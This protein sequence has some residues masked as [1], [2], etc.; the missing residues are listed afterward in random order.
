MKIIGFGGKGR[1]GKTTTAVFLSSWIEETFDDYYVEI[2]PFALPLKI[3]V[4]QKAGYSSWMEYKEEHPTMYR[5]ECQRLGSLARDEYQEYWIDLWGKCVDKVDKMAKEMDKKPVVIVDDVRYTNELHELKL[6]N[7]HTVFVSH[8]RRVLEDADA[9][10]REHESEDLAN[11]TEE[12]MKWFDL[13]VQPPLYYSFDYNVLND[14]PTLQE[15]EESLTK[16]Y[17]HLFGD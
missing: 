6:R 4:A 2:V 16:L 8:G 1:V 17:P 7:A 9:E 3:E 15:Y 13:E 12:A 11:D 10:W 14:Y 5:T